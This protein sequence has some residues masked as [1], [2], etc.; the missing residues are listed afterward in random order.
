MDLQAAQ[1]RHH[2]ERGIGRWAY[3]FTAA[4][5]ATRPDLIGAVVFNPRLPLPAA[6]EALA[7]TGKVDPT[8]GARAA[9]RIYHV[10]SP[11][12]PDETVDGVWPAAVRRAAL[13]VT[14][15]DLIPE[16]YAARYLAA[17]GLR[18]RYR[19]R[20]LLLRAADRVLAISEATRQDAV[21]RLGL[22]PRRVVNIGAGISCRFVPPGSRQEALER[23]RA[24][25][26]GLEP[27]FLLSV[28]GEDERKN[29]SG[30][31]AGYARIAPELRRDHQLVVACN[32]TSGYRAQL[33]AQA[34]RLGVA[35]RVRFTG[36]VDDAT[37]IALY[38]ATDLF[39]FPSFYEGFGLPVAEAM[40]CGAP[41]V[42]SNTSATAEIVDPAGAFDPADPAAIAA[43]IAAALTDPATQAALAAAAALPAPGWGEVAGK[44]VAAYEELL[45]ER[46]VTRAS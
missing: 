46:A 19:T 13:V 34:S 10:L 8:G 12:E 45:T 37:L 15:Y 20:Q 7:A 35:S 2:G 33:S 17:V 26:A 39:V 32:L 31:L 21:D 43:A 42:G 24:A 11:F 27:G 22:D 38:Q 16:L 41:V 25:V 9:A 4:V 14:L 30:L 3:E 1:S 29:L 18:R 44:A 23:A 36:Y 28:G 5:T 6:A 40:A